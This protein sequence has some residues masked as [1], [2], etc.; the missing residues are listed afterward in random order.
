MEALLPE[1]DDVHAPINFAVK[2]LVPLKKKLLLLQKVL[3]QML[4]GLLK[5]A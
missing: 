4:V 3:E 1:R 5:R 2:T